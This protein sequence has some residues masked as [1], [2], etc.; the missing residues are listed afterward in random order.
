M[1]EKKITLRTANSTCECKSV[2]EWICYLNN[3]PGTP[4]PVG[5]QGPIGPTGPQGPQGLQGI[6]GPQGAIGPAGP[7]GP[8]G[9]KGDVGLAG[10]AGPQ[11]PQ[12]VPGAVGPQGPQGLQ[13]LK[14]DVGP[15][16]PQG[17]AGPAGAAGTAATITV[18][19]VTEVPCGT[20]PTVVNGGTPSA[21]VLNFGLPGCEQLPV[22]S[23]NTANNYSKTVPTNTLLIWEGVLATDPGISGTSGSPDIVLAGYTPTTVYSMF[24]TLNV[25]TTTDNQ[26]VNLNILK[27]GNSIY[28]IWAYVPKAGT[29]QSITWCQLLAPGTY[30]VQNSSA[31]VAITQGLTACNITRVRK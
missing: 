20:K 11:G 10:P 27:N 1:S 21:A 2:S 3:K 15:A 14:G 28:D 5:P 9:P 17:I 19:T 7:Q 13:G 24:L 6:P 23:F 12:G 25:K 18:G 29:A 8:V 30:S 26:F 16:G 4:G 31:S 22:G